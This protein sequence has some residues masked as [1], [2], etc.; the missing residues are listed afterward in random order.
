MRSRAFLDVP[1]TAYAKAREFYS[2][3]PKV[4]N[5]PFDRERFTIQEIPSIIQS[6]PVLL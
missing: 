1:L 4:A 5:A 6:S 3:L 2:T